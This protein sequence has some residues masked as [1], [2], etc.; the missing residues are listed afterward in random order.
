MV[1]EAALVVAVRLLLLDLLQGLLR[2]EQLEYV[3]L[4]VVRVRVRD[5]EQVRG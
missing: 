2:V 5:G 4:Q 3:L 1:P